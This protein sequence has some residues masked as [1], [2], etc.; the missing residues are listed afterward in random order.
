MIGIR[1]ESPE[2]FDYI[3]EVLAAAFSRP[4]EA[5]IVR[6]LRE[7]PDLVL[8][9]AAE[10]HGELVGH[11]AFS[12]LAATSAHGVA[13]LA[14]LAPMAVRPDRQRKGIGS[15]L[16]RRGLEMIRDM[17]FPAVVVLGD[18]VYYGR[19]GFKIE[20][21]ALLGCP[22]PGPY[23]QALELTPGCLRDMGPARLDF[24]APLMPGGEI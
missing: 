24:A 16:I 18:P 4:D 8:A 19:F 3:D 1:T 15:A 11:I 7:T 5:R 10:S 9:L 23:L 20:T 13:Q 12:R 2:D 21:A 22:Y 17:K 14:C 6:R